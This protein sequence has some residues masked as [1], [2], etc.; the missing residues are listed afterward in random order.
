MLDISSLFLY[1]RYRGRGCVCIKAPGVICIYRFS[2][3]NWICHCV[4]FFLI[5][6]ISSVREVILNLAAAMF[7]WI[8]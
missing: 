1:N 3:F 4:M 5:L 7:L 8:V 6:E 2:C